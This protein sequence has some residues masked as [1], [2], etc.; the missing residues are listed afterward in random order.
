[1]V[2]G[3]RVEVYGGGQFEI[4]GVVADYS[5]NMGGSSLFKVIAFTHEFYFDLFML[6]YAPTTQLPS[7]TVE[8]S[9]RLGNVYLLIDD[10]GY[11]A[12]EYIIRLG[13]RYALYIIYGVEISHKNKNISLNHDNVL[14]RYP[15][16]APVSSLV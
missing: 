2:L 10:F 15:M 1:M 6:N 3:G 11:I 12:S 4:V 8:S 9:F 5:R 13:Q 16:P 7:A 14:A